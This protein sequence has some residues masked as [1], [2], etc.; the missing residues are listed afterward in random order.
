MEGEGSAGVEVCEHDCVDGAEHRGIEAVDGDARLG[1]D[2]KEHRCCHRCA[3]WVEGEA[4]MEASERRSDEET[5]LTGQGMFLGLLRRL[6][7]LHSP[8]PLL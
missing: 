5:T 1:E 2:A 3:Q 8:L 4:R 6:E 7:P